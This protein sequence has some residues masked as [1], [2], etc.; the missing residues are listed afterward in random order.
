MEGNEDSLLKK[1]FNHIS[2]LLHIVL[3][4]P[5]QCKHYFP[6][7]FLAILCTVFSSILGILKASLEIALKLCG[8]ISLD[9]KNK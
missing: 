3:L 4:L 9:V 5:E 8:S 2:S 6:S 7:H 1:Q